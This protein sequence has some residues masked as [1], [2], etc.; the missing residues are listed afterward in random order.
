MSQYFLQ[1]FINSTTDSCTCC[2]THCEQ[3]LDTPKR[4]RLRLQNFKKTMKNLKM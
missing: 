4:K 3:G 2:N 1:Y